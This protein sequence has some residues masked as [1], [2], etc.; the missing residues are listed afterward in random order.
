VHENYTAQKYATES[1]PEKQMR[2]TIKN[3]ATFV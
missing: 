1:L 2:K 3:Y